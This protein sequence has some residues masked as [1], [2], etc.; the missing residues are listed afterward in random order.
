MKLKSF[1][2]NYNTSYLAIVFSLNFFYK[3]FVSFPQ[4]WESR[5]KIFILNT[6]HWIPAFARRTILIK[7]M[8]F[9]LIVVPMSAFAITFPLA[10]GPDNCGSYDNP[11]SLAVDFGKLIYKLEVVGVVLVGLFALVV[12]VFFI[13]KSL[14]AS[15][16]SAEKAK[17]NKQAGV[18]SISFFAAVF[19]GALFIAGMNAFVKS[20][21]SALLKKFISM[22]GDTPIL[23]TLHTYAADPFANHLP[24]ALVVET[25]YDALIIFFQFAMRW[26][27]IPI[28]IGSW[29]WAGFLFIQAQGNPEKIS[30][31]RE[32]LWN[33]LV[34]TLILMFALGIAFAFR[35]TINQIFS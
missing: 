21:Y 6:R 7:I 5:L 26:I 4:R 8:F 25:P 11:C 24:N 16:S 22:V 18:I 3:Y 33:T 14:W 34:K 1:L 13:W 12:L 10:G 23:T 19:L 15:D 17:L 2:K 31:A 30:H 35:N 28:V 32:K 9:N 29:V 27:L 20:E